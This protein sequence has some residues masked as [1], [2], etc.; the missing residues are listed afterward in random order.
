VAEQEPEIVETMLTALDTWMVRCAEVATELPQVRPM[1]EA[2][3]D[4]MKQRLRD[5][6]C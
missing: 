4:E 1:G 3:Y 6:E 2:I 5:A